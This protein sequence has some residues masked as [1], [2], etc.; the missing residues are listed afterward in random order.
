MGKGFVLTLGPIVSRDTLKP[1]W[2]CS[3]SSSTS[4]GL[5]TTLLF[6]MMSQG[7]WEL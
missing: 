2:R 6:S 1:G 7:S 4:Q 3:M 5:A